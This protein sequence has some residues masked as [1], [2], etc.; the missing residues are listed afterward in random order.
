ML[1]YLIE[2]TLIIALFAWLY[3]RQRRDRDRA[4]RL[5]PSQMPLDFDE[6][7]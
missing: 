7:S 5:R 4:S 6:E 1:G 2:F 3:R